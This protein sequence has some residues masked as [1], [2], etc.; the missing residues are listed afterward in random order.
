MH[1]K[2][3][4]LYLLYL[5]ASQLSGTVHLWYNMIQ[6]NTVLYIPLELTVLLQLDTPYLILT[7]VREFCGKQLFFNYKYL[8]KLDL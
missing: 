8:W 2:S 6:Y 3:S 7:D 4:Q 5:L 1:T